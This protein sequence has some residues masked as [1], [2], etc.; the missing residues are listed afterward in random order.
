[1]SSKP[2]LQLGL[3]LANVL[4]SVWLVVPLLHSPVFLNNFVGRWETEINDKYKHL[5]PLVGLS[6][7]SLC[8][9]L[10]LRTV[11]SQSWLL[12]IGGGWDRS[13]KG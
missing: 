5:S 7:H 8:P 3:G 11:S 1:M 12:A 9:P 4:Y 6:D 10:V 13:D 2:L